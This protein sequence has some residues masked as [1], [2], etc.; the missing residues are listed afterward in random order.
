MTPA[1][2]NRRLAL[3]A[4]TLAGV[5]LLACSKGAFAANTVELLSQTAGGAKTEFTVK[6]QVLII[7]SLLGLLPVMVMMMTSFTRFVIV[8]SLLRQALGL[9][10]G[11]PNRIVTGIALILTLLVMRPVGDKIW[12]DAFVPF[13]EDRITLQ[14][15]L[16]KA[17]EP[18]T[19]FML[20]QTNKAALAQMSRLAGEKDVAR[21]QDHAFTVKLAAFVLSELKTAF[22]IG[23]LLFIPFL[24]IDL[25]VS[26]VLMAMG[27]MMLS[28]LVISLPLKLLLFV[29]V[30]GWTLTV[31]TLVTSVQAY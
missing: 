15:A 29:L 20:A 16:L 14:Q 25:V 7:M 1:T 5:A 13:D 6:T 19:K 8:L 30:D 9:Q 21:P 23:C 27:M 11:L 10:Q 24:V 3:A 12:T 17:E 31:N 18:L 4:A 22:Q 28:P 2:P 26:S